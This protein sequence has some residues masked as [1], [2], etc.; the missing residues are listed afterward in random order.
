MSL[1]IKPGVGFAEST[2][3]ECETFGALANTQLRAGDGNAAR[4]FNQTRRDVCG[5]CGWLMPVA[6]P[7]RFEYCDSRRRVGF[8][9]L[10]KACDFLARQK[11][12]DK[13]G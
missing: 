7:L 9:S 1:E 3:G 8:V 4:A 11:R 2:P 6:R 12:K 13:H 5:L 10:C